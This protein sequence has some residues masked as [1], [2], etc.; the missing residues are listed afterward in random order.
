[1][2]AGHEEEEED[3]GERQ[4]RIIRRGDGSGA[5]YPLARALLP[6]NESGRRMIEEENA[7][8]ANFGCRLVFLKEEW[9]HLEIEAPRSDSI[10]TISHG[11][12]PASFRRNHAPPVV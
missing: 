10:G 1:M 9:P 4:R 2:N 6:K 5:R 8:E 3:E 11:R 12:H 7:M